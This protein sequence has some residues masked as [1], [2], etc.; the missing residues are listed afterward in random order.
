MSP[1]PGGDQSSSDDGTLAQIIPLRRRDPGSHTPCDRPSDASGVFDPPDEPEPLNEYS[2]W[3]RPAAELIRRQPDVPRASAHAPGAPTTASSSR[4]LWLGAA[5]IVLLTIGAVLALSL[6]SQRA[7]QRTAR[8]LASASTRVYASY[9]DIAGSRAHPARHSKRSPANRTPRTHSAGAKTHTRSQ[10]HVTI[11]AS[12]TESTRSRAETKTVPASDETAPSLSN[13]AS[14]SVQE[15]PS[16]TSA[17]T[18]S[19]ATAPPA[20]EGSST[21]PTAG[22]GTPVA[23]NA[24]HEFGFEQ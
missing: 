21:A 22:E 13:T 24:S 2:V 9:A 8:R 6:A 18:P 12:P 17:T 15:S 4:R 23:S 10:N 14:T 11:T 5:T 1:P 20:G 19:S 7:R 3:E 16:S